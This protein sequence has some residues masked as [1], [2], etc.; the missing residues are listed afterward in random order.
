MC[1]FCSDARV[2][3]TLELP[4]NVRCQDASPDREELAKQLCASS[5]IA[6]DS[7]R[8]N[9]LDEEPEDGVLPCGAPGHFAW[10][11]MLAGADRIIAS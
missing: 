8:P 2:I 9:T 7:L 3:Q 11:E 5:G 1:S 10:R 6:H 4:A